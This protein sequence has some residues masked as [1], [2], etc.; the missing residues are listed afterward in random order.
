MYGLHPLLL[1][2]YIL[3]TRLGENKDPQPIRV[4]TSQLSELRK[5]HENRL[6]AQDLVISNQLNRSLWSQNRF[7][8]T[9][10]Q[11]G[12]YVSWFLGA[13]SKHALKF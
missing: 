10:F 4:L 7:I 11:F 9:K 12:D 13:V 3:P 5:L 1:I 2:E 6:I 8:K